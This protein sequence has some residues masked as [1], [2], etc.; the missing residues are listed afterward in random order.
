MNDGELEHCCALLGVEPGVSAEGL[1]KAYVQKSYALIRGGAS[2]AEREQ[3]KQA[4]A[5]LH[6]HVE[7]RGPAPVPA[8][9]VGGLG[10]PVADQMAGAAIQ[11]E[12]APSAP[13]ADPYDPFAFDNW[14]INA[15]APPLVVAAAVLLQRSFFGF[16]LQ[17]FHVWIHEFGHATVAWLAG[18]R[19]L[20]LPIGWTNVS[21]EKSLFVYFGVLFLFGV[22]AWAGVRERKV[23]PVV[24]AL[25][26]AVFQAYLTWFLPENRVPLWFAF[27]GI[28]GE[29]YLAAG[30]MA[31]FYLRMPDKFRWG[32]CRYLFLFICAASFFQTYAFWKAVKRGQEGIPYG[33]MINGE[34]D[35][36]GDMNVLHEDFNWT[37]HDI[38]HTYNR[39]GDAC[40]LALVAVYVFFALGLDRR[41]GRVLRPAA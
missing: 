8:P 22:M 1:K 12:V 24:L 3:L 17:G 21:G 30:L 27:G 32:G 2:E 6:A 16:F 20:P 39:L 13:R 34:E 38:I 36:A 40:V 28:G 9:A 29:F 14:R 35:A 19:A 37:Q 15:F 31:L 41:I 26:L 7:Q 25:G 4:H 33:S 5:T 23:W 10:H 18:R 11:L